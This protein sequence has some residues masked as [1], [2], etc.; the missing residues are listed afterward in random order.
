MHEYQSTEKLHAA[1]PSL[2]ADTR[3]D[4]RVIQARC[5]VHR[6]RIFVPI[7][8]QMNPVQVL[9]YCYL[10][11][12]FNI[13]F[14]CMPKRPSFGISLYAFFRMRATCPAHPILL[15]LLMLMKEI[16]QLKTLLTMTVLR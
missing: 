1:A 9:P 15:D 14:S 8:S 2:E 12:N 13:I 3:L 4:N 16:S 6:N 10:R 11:Q 5:R 7:L